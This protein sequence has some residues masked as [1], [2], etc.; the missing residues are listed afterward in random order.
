MQERCFYTGSF[1]CLLSSYTIQHF[2][3][4]RGYPLR[5][6]ISVN[7]FASILV[8]IDS[9][10]SGKLTHLCYC[11]S[12]SSLRLVRIGDCCQGLPPF[13]DIEELVDDDEDD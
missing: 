2:G 1:S 10:G 9:C 3:M 4:K 13:Y 5:N 11:C 6:C 8:C 7:V 12:C